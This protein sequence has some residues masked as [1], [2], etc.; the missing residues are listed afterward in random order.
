MARP[1]PVRAHLVCGG[2]PPG[3]PAGH[4]HDYARLRLLEALEQREVVASVANDFHDIERWLP[5][6]DL[7]I[8][9]VSGPFLTD[10]QSELVADWLGEGGKWL[11]LHGS[12]GGKAARVEGGLRAMVK[13]SHHETLG[14]FF[15]NH[16]PMRRF[17][18]EIN[19]RHPLAKNVPERFEVVDELYMIEVIDPRADVF[20]T[21]EMAV[22][23]S[24]PG[25]G[26]VYERDS[27]LLPDGKSRPL[28]F[29]RSTGKGGVTYV[30]LGHAHTPYSNSQPFVDASVEPSGTTPLLLRG[31][32][33]TEGY[34]ALLSNAVT[35][36]TARPA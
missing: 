36:G 28:A 15:L 13:T 21:T 19:P 25:F 4:D 23:P 30:A 12:S 35:W 33:E 31:P 7:L 20:L 22:D 32:W 2:F 3:Q 9:Y 16:P 10:E 17:E 5:L 26:F 6:A 14:G 27:S 18:V 1:T 8:T 24:P 11:A 34:Q 29:T